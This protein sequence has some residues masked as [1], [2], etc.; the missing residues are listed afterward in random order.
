MTAPKLFMGLQQIAFAHDYPH[1]DAY[2]QADIE[3]RQRPAKIY[4][5]S[6]DVQWSTDRRY[7]GLPR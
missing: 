3:G 2:A 1:L 5:I 7:W 6:H 4:G